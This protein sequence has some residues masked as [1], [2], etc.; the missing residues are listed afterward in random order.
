MKTQKKADE[1]PITLYVKQDLMRAAIVS[2]IICAFIL[3]LFI[4]KQNSLLP[5]LG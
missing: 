3:L 5:I 1:T 4:A 2:G